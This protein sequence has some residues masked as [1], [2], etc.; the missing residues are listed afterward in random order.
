MVP[1]LS[2][3]TDVVTLVSVVKIVLDNVSICVKEGDE[4]NELVTDRC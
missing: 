3:F 1:E 2:F 4:L